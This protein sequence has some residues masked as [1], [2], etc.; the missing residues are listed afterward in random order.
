MKN[1]EVSKKS[2]MCGFTSSDTLL[3]VNCHM[4]HLKSRLSHIFLQ[5]NVLMKIE[6]VSFF[7]IIIVFVKD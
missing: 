1:Q 4:C 7:I 6:Q 3:A 2:F 5:Q